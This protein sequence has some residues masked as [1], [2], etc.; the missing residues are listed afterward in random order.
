MGGVIDDGTLTRC[1]M[2]CCLACSQSN[3]PYFD[4]AVLLA[5]YLQLGKITPG[6]ISV[7]SLH[8][9]RLQ[10][11]CPTGLSVIYRLESLFVFLS[12]SRAYV[13]LVPVH[14]DHQLPF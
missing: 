4:F 14:I 11:Q 3:K 8:Y 12:L 5:R 7:Q 2:F 13:C 10:N 6:P 9:R 1:H